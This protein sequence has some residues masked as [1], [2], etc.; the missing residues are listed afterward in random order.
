MLISLAHK[1]L[2]PK[3]IHDDVLVDE[4]ADEYLYFNCI[5]FINSVK[6]SAS[7]QWHSPLLNDIS[8]VKTWR[9]VNQGLL[10][11]YRHELFA[12]LPIMQHFL[13]GKLIGG[14]GW[15]KRFELFE[16]DLFGFK[17]WSDCLET[18]AASA[19]V[20]DCGDQAD[21]EKHAHK[22]SHE[23][24]IEEFIPDSSRTQQCQHYNIVGNAYAQ[25]CSVLKRA[26]SVGDD[27]QSVADIDAMIGLSIED[28]QEFDDADA[29]EN[30]TNQDQ[31]NSKSS[32]QHTSKYEEVVVKYVRGANG[33]QIPIM[34][35]LA[36][37]HAS[38][39]QHQSGCR[40][41]G[42]LGGKKIMPGADA[43]IDGEKSTSGV[44]NTTSEDD[45]TIS[46]L[47]ALPVS[48][49]YAMGQQAPTCCGIRI[50]SAIAAKMY[51]QNRA[52][53]PFD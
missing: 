15:Q 11:M 18:A 51:E 50:P 36:S 9:K 38:L 26:E 17:Q 32:A 42:G 10:K 6:T 19:T 23:I 37:S 16:G 14:V 1:Y 39:I 52:A 33:Q 24:S 30:N 7:L 48:N 40:F 45:N 53:L 27:H 21:D 12:K 22:S 43:G 47:P 25:L 4:L 29:K 3:S 49:T 2:R 41:S 20:D 46:H 31:Q 28:E 5:R 13:F 8:G 34:G 35:R 44:D